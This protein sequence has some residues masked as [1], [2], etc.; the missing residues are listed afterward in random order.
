MLVLK[1]PPRL[2]VFRFNVT[3]YL[4]AYPHRAVLAIHPNYYTV[5]LPPL[6]KALLKR[7]KLTYSNLLISKY[8]RVSRQELVYQLLVLL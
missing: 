2:Y 5:E 1:M 3:V 4:T 8:Y 6:R 7:G